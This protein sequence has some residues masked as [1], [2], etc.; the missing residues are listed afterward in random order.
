M[1]E[2]K[3]V[4]AWV[5]RHAP[6]PSQI[7]TL[8]QKIGDFYLV[9]ISRTFTSYKEVLDE[10]KK[11]GARYAVVVLPLSM[12]AQLVSDKSIVWLWAEMEGLHECGG[13]QECRDFDPSRDVWLPLHGQPRGR[14]MRFKQFRKILRVE[15][16]T[17]PF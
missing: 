3:V 6:L 5:S 15:M 7:E 4:V 1:D 12:I 11:V 9:Q 17:E 8:K 10:I 13:P 2:E 16:I 14:H